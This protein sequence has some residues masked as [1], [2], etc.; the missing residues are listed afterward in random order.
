MTRKRRTFSEAFK[1]KVALAA[2]R[3]E[4]TIAE[5]ASRFA[6]HPSQVTSWKQQ[7]VEGLREVFADG[8][9]RCKG[10]GVFILGWAGSSTADREGA[11]LT[12]S[13][14][15]WPFASATTPRQTA[16]RERSTAATPPVP[17]PSAGIA[18][19][20]ANLAEAAPDRRPTGPR[21]RRACDA[22]D[23]TTAR[24]RPVGPCWPAAD[25]ARRSAAPSTGGRLPGGSPAA[26]GKSASAPRP[27]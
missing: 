25:C 10:S 6:V 4:G 11:G 26:C 19:A 2:I 18:R 20:R 24:R 3:G 21:R 23:S 27:D 12:A 5:L 22:K 14:V 1:A 13:P 15:A 16:S 8:R 17:L 9:G 7:A